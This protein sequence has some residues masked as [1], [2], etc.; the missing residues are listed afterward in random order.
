MFAEIAEALAT[1]EHNHKD[2]LMRFD[3]LLGTGSRQF[4]TASILLTHAAAYL[5]ALT[6]KTIKHPIAL[7]IGDK[8]LDNL[9]VVLLQK[10]MQITRERQDL[11]LKDAILDSS[12]FR[13]MSK[14]RREKLDEL[15]KSTE[16]PD[17]EL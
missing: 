16:V 11:T 2:D 7:T 8:E 15:Q 17:G 14:V 6:G 3:D 4:I 10:L 12:F 5:N 1:F 13:R 9:T